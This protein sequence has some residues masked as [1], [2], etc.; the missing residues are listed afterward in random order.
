MGKKLLL[1]AGRSKNKL[2][3]GHCPMGGEGQK[4][5]WGSAGKRKNCMQRDDHKGKEKP[6][7]G[8]KER[9]RDRYDERYSSP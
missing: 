1:N 3:L 9:T 7:I 8:S 6:V 5:V 4:T 2:T